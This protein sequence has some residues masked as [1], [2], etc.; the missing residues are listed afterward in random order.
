MRA[1][2]FG[3]PIKWRLP[4]AAL[5]LAVGGDIEAPFLE[6]R[7]VFNFNFRLFDAISRHCWNPL[8]ISGSSCAYGACYQFEQLLLGRIPPREGERTYKN[9]FCAFD[10][11]RYCDCWA[12]DDGWPAGF[13]TAA[14]PF[15]VSCWRARPPGHCLHARM[16]SIWPGRQVHQQA[17]FILAAPGLP[18]RPF[19]APRCD[20]KLFV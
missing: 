14:T 13:G 1:G 16:V 12:L 5:D 17:R 7:C 4:S 20:M 11:A 6:P 3:L 10:G 2:G 15:S 18:G 9:S 19:H 8:M